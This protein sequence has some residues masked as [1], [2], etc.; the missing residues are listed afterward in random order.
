MKIYKYTYSLI[1]DS[2]LVDLVVESSMKDFLKEFY[3]WYGVV[4]SILRYSGKGENQRRKACEAG[5][6]GK[7][8]E[9]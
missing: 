8:R 3:V 7:L 6:V 1:A 4:V 9:I 5:W 2:V